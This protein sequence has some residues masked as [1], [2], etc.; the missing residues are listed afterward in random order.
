MRT[1]RCPSCSGEIRIYHDN[2]P[3]DEVF[4][5]DCEREYSLISLSP[6]RL[7]PLEI[8]DDYAFEADEY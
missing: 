4:C 1:K 7:T 2:E 5:D 8:Y 6:I 3:G